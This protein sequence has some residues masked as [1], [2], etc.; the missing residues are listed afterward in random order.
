M[1]KRHQKTSSTPST[2]SIISSS[3]FLEGL[4]QSRAA[5]TSRDFQLP[6]ND[7]RVYQ[8]ISVLD[9]LEDEEIPKPQDI[10]IIYKS[11]LNHERTK[12]KIKKK[13]KILDE[14]D[15][16][17]TV[18]EEGTA[19][20]IRSPVVK[21]GRSCESIRIHKGEDKL[22][23]PNRPKLIGKDLEI[24]KQM[25]WNFNS[26]I[27]ELEKVLKEKNL[28]LKAVE[29]ELQVKEEIL[30][31]QTQQLKSQKKIIELLQSKLK[32]AQ[33]ENN[34]LENITMKYEISEQ[35]RFLL[36]QDLGNANETIRKL[37]EKLE[38]YELLKEDQNSQ[39]IHE[40]S[41]LILSRNSR[42]SFGNKL[43]EAF[44]AKFHSLENEREEA[45]EKYKETINKNITLLSELRSSDEFI[46]YVSELLESGNIE[47]ASFNLKNM[48]EFVNNRIESV[49]LEIEENEALLSAEQ[50]VERSYCTSISY[51]TNSRILSA[52]ESPV[53]RSKSIFNNIL[54]D[55]D[56]KTDNSDILNQLE[57]KLELVEMKEHINATKDW[58][59]YVQCQAAA[60]EQFLD[61]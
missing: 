27:E 7:S 31:N 12:R 58:L 21:R 5:L 30:N 46:L 25:T 45:I 61:N 44:I 54:P 29:L 3:R 49:Q 57:Q 11:K 43:Q 51:A 37:Q 28:T 60:L 35:N 33:I 18:G 48:Q 38:N 20:S 40:L 1:N 55:I 13:Q 32:T 52:L 53:D 39:T 23:I 19:Q 15:V 6:S 16:N 59:N 50:P 2:A 9:T 24:D 17:E 34:E 26:R 14:L 47:E 36:V 8:Q 42:K 4:V 10:D 22:H 56:E 41:S